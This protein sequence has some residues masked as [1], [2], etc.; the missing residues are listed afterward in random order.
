MAKYKEHHRK[1]P[2]SFYLNDSELDELM[3]KFDLENMDYSN[4]GIRRKLASYIRESIFEGEVKIKTISPLAQ[5]QYLE[6]SRFNNNFNQF[7]KALNAD[8]K[9]KSIVTIRKL[10]AKATSLLLGVTKEDGEDN[11]E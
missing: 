5:E 8:P 10:I 9:S 4:I 6:L 7:V 11:E 1:H 2:V 3:R